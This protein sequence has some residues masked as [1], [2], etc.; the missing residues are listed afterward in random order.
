MSEADTYRQYLDD[1]NDVMK[2][3]S[4]RRLL[5]HVLNSCDIYATTFTG[6]SLTFF[7]EGRRAVG[8]QLIRDMQAMPDLYLKMQTEC[9]GFEDYRAA[10]ADGKISKGS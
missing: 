9:S 3:T 2:S 7:K 6:N 1:L 5:W 10:N 4:G 8:L